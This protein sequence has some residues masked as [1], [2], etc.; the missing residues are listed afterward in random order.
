M[1]DERWTDEEKRLQEQGRQKPIPVRQA[2]PLV[3]CRKYVDNP[4]TAEEV[5][6]FLKELER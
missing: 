5:E 2:P 6:E 4:V 1:S 3:P